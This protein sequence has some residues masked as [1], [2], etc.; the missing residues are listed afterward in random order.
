MT[1]KTEHVSF[2]DLLGKTFTSVVEDGDSMTLTT[3]GV[4]YD[5]VHEQ[6][7][8]ESVYIESIVGELSDLVGEP[9][10]MAEES[11]QDDPNAS[12]RGMWTFYKLATRLGYVDIRWYGSSNGYYGVSVSCIKTSPEFSE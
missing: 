4:R 7:C 1:G 5:L 12:E 10:L 2:S 3:A 6:D 8:C 11:S 9:I